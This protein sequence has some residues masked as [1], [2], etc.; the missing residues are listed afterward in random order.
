[1]DD[2]RESPAFPIIERLRALG[3]SVDYN[4]PWIPHTVPTRDYDLGMRSV[5]LDAQALASYTAVVVCTN[6]SSYDWQWLADH[7][8]LIVDTRNALSGVDG[9]ARIVQA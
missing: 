5:A 8:Q 3:A 1:M 7:A 9:H 2:T 4:D 6:H